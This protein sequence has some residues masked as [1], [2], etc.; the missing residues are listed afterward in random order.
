M[1]CS[2]VRLHHGRLRL[3]PPVD[4][5]HRPLLPAPHPLLCTPVSPWKHHCVCSQASP[6]QGQLSPP[7]FLQVVGQR[8]CSEA[9]LSPPPPGF[10]DWLCS[11]RKSQWPGPRWGSPRD[12]VAEQILWTVSSITCPRRR[13]SGPCPPH[14]PCLCMAQW[15]PSGMLPPS[16]RKGFVPLPL[17]EQGSVGCTYRLSLCPSTVCHLVAPWH[18]RRGLWGTHEWISCS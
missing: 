9:L 8:H 12:T 7:S 10:H 1:S 17:E 2:A 15:L 13:G 18:F 3:A 6:S 11:P 14:V 5:G 4:P 16:S